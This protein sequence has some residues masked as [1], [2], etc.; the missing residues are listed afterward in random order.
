MPKMKTKNEAKAVQKPDYGIYRKLLIALTAVLVVAPVLFTLVQMGLFAGEPTVDIKPTAGPDAPVLRVAADYDF[1]PNSYYNSN[2]E[3]S[4]LYIEIVT[5]AANRLGMQVEF[6]TGAWLDCRAM[7]AE[8]D[9]DV[10]LGL[11]IFSNME[12][13]L[14]TIPLCSDELCVYGKEAVD[15]AATLAGRRV[16]LMARSV[17]E[18]SYDLQCEYVE[19][20]TNTEILQAVENGEADYAIC[21]SAVS[22]KLIEKNHL[23]LR[24]GLAIAKSFP[25]MAVSASRPELRTALNEALQSMSRDETIGRLQQ[26]WIDDFTRSR[27][28]RYV[29]KTNQVLYD[30]FI[31]ALI[32]VV[33]ALVIYY[34]LDRRQAR[35]IRSLL[36]V[37]RQLKESNEAALRANRAK[38]VFLSHMSHD[39]RTPVNGILGMAER[40]RRKKDEPETVD[41]CLDKIKGAAGHLLELMDDVLDMSRL[42]VGEVRLTR[43][44]FDLNE[45]LRRVRSI[46]EE[47]AKVKGIALEFRMDGAV[48]TRLLGSPMHLRRILLNL[49][50]NAVKYNRPGGRVDVSVRE[51][52]G[53]DRR[54]ALRFVVRDTG[55][56]MSEEF[57]QK[58]LF[59]PFTQEHD[60]ARTE[61]QGT[62]L[63]MAIVSDLVKFMGGA[64][65]VE[66]RLGEG[67]TFTVQ[68]EFD[69]NPAAPP[70]ATDAQ[71][72]TDISGMRVL[73]AEDNDLNLE[74]ARCMLQD[75]GVKTAE[76]RNGR[77]AVEKF[78]ASEEGAFDAI[79]MDVMMPVMDGMQ[80]ARAIRALPRQDAADVPIIAMTANAFA[81][82]QSRA[83]DCGMTKYLTKPVDPAKLRAALSVCRR[84]A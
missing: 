40:I 21:H 22:E 12:G 80:A 30:M 27:S 65:G 75:A 14:R 59:H 73:V 83:R 31:L 70:A 78:A 44:P 62:G 72:L 18:A 37:Q 11:E 5:E 2:G 46:A 55:I 39:F 35:Y 79:L 64:I 71:P 13:T 74:I 26:K 66:S 19:Y 43:S 15:S 63:G 52:G 25:A 45:E 41:D 9:A 67:T 81:E 8:G 4:G 29:L 3:L 50:S 6:K 34:V 48:H 10:L 36:D 17:I 38:T 47:S 51:V 60:N 68:L 58:S 69:L 56:G 49:V 7:L 76:A 33:S 84:Q 16:A 1:C 57:V 20:N 24:R 32:V 23:D 82:D 77:E 54:V 61:Y 53:D 28:L 42:E